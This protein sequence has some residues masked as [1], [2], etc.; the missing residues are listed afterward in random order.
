MRP[1]SPL[2]AAVVLAAAVAAPE[3]R[4]DDHAVSFPAGQS[5]GAYQPGALEIAAGDS[6][7]FTGAF[8]YHPLVWADADFTTQDDGTTRSY[9]FAKPGLYRFHCAIHATMTGSV[10]VPGNAF[11]TPDFTVAPAAA[12]AGAPVTFTATGFADPDGTIARYEW[13]LD[14]DG[15]FETATSAGQATR[16]YAAAQ[17]LHVG[18]RYVD[19]GHETSPTATR[20]LSIA[21]GPTPALGGGSG[22]SGEG[23]GGASPS[24]ASTD[25]GTVAQPGAPGAATAPKGGGTF[26]ARVR[27]RALTFRAGA[28]TVALTAP[29]AGPLTLTVRRGSTVLARGAR[30]AAAA[31]PLG[32]RVKL[33][34]AGRR[35][36]AGASAAKGLRA[37]LTVSAPR[38]AVVRAV[39]TLRS[40]RRR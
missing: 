18:L 26:A 12:R 10:H 37:T 20:D 28:A 25:P 35:L 19:D 8:G 36:L 21:A 5:A 32:V 15:T 14:G 22:G 13:D 38:R 6:V 31:G 27:S 23:G 16:T 40:R 24:P 34:A 2:L 29:A 1:R 4:A 11:A 7:T 17:T 3:A 39:V 33:T 9:T 30:S